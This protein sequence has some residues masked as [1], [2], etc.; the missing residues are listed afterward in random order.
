MRRAILLM[1]AHAHAHMVRQERWTLRL[2]AIAHAEAVVVRKACLSNHL[3][4]LHHLL[5]LLLN[6]F[7]FFV[8]GLALVLGIFFCQRW[9]AKACPAPEFSSLAAAF[10]VDR[11]ARS[12]L[13]ALV[14]PMCAHGSATLCLSLRALRHEEVESPCRNRTL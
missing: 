5:V 12:W 7:L 8:A 11:R 6:P 13:R 2:I 14:W 10:V 9:A 3:L 1:H 4:L